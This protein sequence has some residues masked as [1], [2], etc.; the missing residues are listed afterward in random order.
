MP[1]RLYDQIG[2]GYARTRRTDPRIAAIVWDRLGTGTSLLNV[3]AGTGSYEPAC[4]CVVAVEP[5]AAMRAQ[6]P[7]GAARCVAGTAEALPFSDNS[8]DVVMSVFSHWHWTDQRKG[9][10]EMRRVA[11]QRVLLIS[12]DRKVADKFWLVDE[13]LP[14]AHALWGAFDET[15]R[16]LGDCEI[17]EMPVPADCIDGFFHAY[18]RRPHAYLDESVRET[19]AV[20]KRLDPGEA[21]RG[22]RQLRTDL[23]RGRWRDRH[24]P[25]LEKHMLDLG[26]RLLVHTCD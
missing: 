13:Y 5:S 17:V 1:E 10:A 8:F 23:H 18:W 3:G 7:E 26:Y 22:L 21:E 11:R 4:R 25:L 6:R 9:L 15:V 12:L 24:A 2:T 19:M 14:S 20:F 16:E